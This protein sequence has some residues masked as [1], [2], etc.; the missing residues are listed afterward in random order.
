MR[1]NSVTLSNPGNSVSSE[2][3]AKQRRHVVHLRSSEDYKNESVCGE[4]FHEVVIDNVVVDASDVT[5]SPR[6]D[7]RH[8]EELCSSVIEM[9]FG[10]NVV[11]N[12]SIKY[13]GNWFKISSSM[14]VCRLNNGC[15]Q[16]DKNYLSS[17]FVSWYNLIIIW[18]EHSK[19]GIPIWI[20]WPDGSES[21]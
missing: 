15:F 20:S 10:Y 3:V 5:V 11:V 19:V 13:L 18:I 17:S 14:Q 6:L 21:K 7:V 8:G 1:I 9:P 4:M 2:Y 16:Q 12:V